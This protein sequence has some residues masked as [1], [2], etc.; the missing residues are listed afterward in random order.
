MKKIVILSI[1]A[2]LMNTLYAQDQETVE[3]NVDALKDI[4]SP[5]ANLLG[6]ANTDIA[7]PNDPTAFMLNLSQ[8]TDNFTDVPVNYAV[9]LAPAWLLGA[10]NIDAD[11]FVSNSIGS[12]IWQT[13]V[14]SLAVNNSDVTV[15]DE[16]LKNTAFAA[17]LKFSILRGDIS[18]ETDNLIK[19][20]LAK[21]ESINQETS[22]LLVE[23]LG[24]NQEYQNTQDKIFDPATSDAERE[25][26]VKLA[27]AIIK[28]IALE[29]SNETE[30]SR[31][32]LEKVAKRMD[33]TRKGFKL[34]FNAAASFN[35]PD[36]IYSNGTSDKIAAWLTA[37]YDVSDVFSFLGIARFLHNADETFINDQN[38]MAIEDLSLFNAGF[39]LQYEKG[40]F[41]FSGE[42]LFQ[43]AINNDNID[44]GNK[45]LLNAKYV[46]SKNLVLALSFGRDFNNN[47]TQDGN[48]ISALNFI[49]GFGSKRDVTKLD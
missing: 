23:K 22:R 45:F 39:K 1:C 31:K 17:G 29:I 32:S 34:D 12:N 20:S 25:I 5:A 14:V 15:D 2:F 49:K 8:A 6:I 41:S 27:D 38:I 11:K 33:F 13:M 21:M 48:V 47:I 28:L 42:Y 19:E 16:A 43:N 44:S 4:Q 46:V 7:K 37:S 40:D 9:D 30:D 26:N 18:T 24:E 35:F 3:V 10:K 36:Q